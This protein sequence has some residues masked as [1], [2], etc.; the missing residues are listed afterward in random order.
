MNKCQNVDCKN[1]GIKVRVL[2]GFGNKPDEEHEIY[3]CRPCISLQ[4][5]MKGFKN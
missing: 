2:I 3:M 4:S 1:A 5:S